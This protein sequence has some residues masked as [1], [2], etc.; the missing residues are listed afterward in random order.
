MQ[1]KVPGEKK[2]VGQDR[3]QESSKPTG[4]GADNK[5]V[6]KGKD[7][8]PKP[9]TPAK[10][11]TATAPRFGRRPG[12]PQQGEYVVRVRMPKPYKREILGVILEHFGS[13]LQVKCLDGHTRI[14]RIPG[15]IRYKLRVR[16]GDVV[17]VQK[18]TV[19]ENEKG[20]YLYMYK[21]NQVSQLLRKGMITEEDLMI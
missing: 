8:T 13:K 19:Q 12:G 14:C 20:D 11:N 5:E 16:A 17:L 1:D 21:R 18:W 2:E 9:T 6:P 3:G 4:S 7:T 15:K 10:T